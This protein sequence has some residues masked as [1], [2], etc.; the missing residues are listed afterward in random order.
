MGYCSPV[1]NST[2]GP[3]GL[4]KCFNRKV[5]RNCI[6][7]AEKCVSFDQ[8]VDFGSANFS[9]QYDILS[10]N[11]VK[12]NFGSDGKTLVLNLP[13]VSTLTLEEFISGH[14]KIIYLA[15]DGPGLAADLGIATASSELIF[16]FD[17]NA[18]KLIIFSGS[19]TAGKIPFAETSEFST[20]GFNA[21]S[22]SFRVTLTTDDQ[23]T[24]SVVFPEPGRI[25]QRRHHGSTCHNG[26]NS[27]FQS[28]LFV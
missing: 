23:P 13:I 22:G 6:S 16:Q 26:L 8:Q 4:K 2:Q 15:N 17:S 19:D 21:N 28:L 20:I 27:F 5:I 7:G 25:E 24:C 18:G 9:V 1:Q 10:G 12:I 14:N 11:D 3:V